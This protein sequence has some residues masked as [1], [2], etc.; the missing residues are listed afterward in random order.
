MKTQIC[1]TVQRNRFFQ[2]PTATGFDPTLMQYSLEALYASQDHQR[3]LCEMQVLSIVCIETLIWNSYT[4][5][6]FNPI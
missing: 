2:A 5:R 6:Q 3:K 4:W 1:L